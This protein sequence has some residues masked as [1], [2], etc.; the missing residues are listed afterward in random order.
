MQADVGP[1]LSELIQFAVIIPAIAVGITNL[2]EGGSEPFEWRSR[3]S[4]LGWDLCVL[5]LGAEGGVV[6][7]PSVVKGFA[8]TTSM[9]GTM[10]IMF[11]STFGVAL[12]T[13]RIKRVSVIS[14]RRALVVL[15]FGGA[16]LAIPIYVARHYW[17]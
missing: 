11:L 12:I 8:T 3:L 2:I 17:R 10:A 16:A 5:A 6:A 1:R 9:V 7:H 14:G 13:A 15:A 4:K